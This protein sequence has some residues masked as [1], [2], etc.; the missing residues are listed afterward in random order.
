[1][2]GKLQDLASEYLSWQNQR[3]RAEEELNRLK[4]QIVLIARA[5]KIKKIKSGKNQLLIVSQSETRFPQQGEPGRAQLEKIVR[6]SAEAEKAFSFDIV[7]LGNAY[8]EKKLT[9]KLMTQLKPFAKREK[10]TKIVVKK[11]SV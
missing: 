3:E 10:T 2:A 7:R 1:M 8:D 9:K 6:Q 5:G 11:A 4:N